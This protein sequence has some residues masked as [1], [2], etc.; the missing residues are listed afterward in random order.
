MTEKIEITL[1]NSEHIA[2]DIA[3]REIDIFDPEATVI[4]TTEQV[5]KYIM[6]EWAKNKIGIAGYYNDPEEGYEI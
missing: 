6:R 1:T 2:L 5:I 4:Q 3:K